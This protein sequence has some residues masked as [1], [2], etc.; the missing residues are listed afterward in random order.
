MLPATS[1]GGTGMTN[2]SRLAS[3]GAAASLIF[4]SS[5]MART[6]HL[7]WYYLSSLP[8]LNGS[9]DANTGPAEINGR[10]FPPSVLMSG[11]IYGDGIGHAEY[12]LKR[13]CTSLRFNAGVLDDQSPDS[14]AQ[15]TVGG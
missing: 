7:R 9:A 10:V 6:P 4:C 15:F 13:R 5:A 2:L 8:I 11:G 14:A 1:L 12:N 3:A